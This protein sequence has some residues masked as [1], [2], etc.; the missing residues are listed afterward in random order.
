[1]RW[2]SSRTPRRL[3]CPGRADSTAMYPL[4]LSGRVVTLRD[5]R[6]GDA[7]A[8]LSVVG[9]DLV[10]RWLSFDSR[11]AVGAAAMLEGAI[12]RAQQQ[13]RTEFYLAVVLPTT[14]ELVGF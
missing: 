4:T 6:N 8:V 2:R 14:D 10:T 11:D 9:D 12:E 13:V 3:R 7:A 1:M 5:F